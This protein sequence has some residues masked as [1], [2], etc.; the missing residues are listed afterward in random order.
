MSGRKTALFA[1]LLIAHGIAYSQ[2]GGN[3]GELQK[4]EA[5]PAVDVTPVAEEKKEAPTRK[6]V[7]APVPETTTLTVNAAGPRLVVCVSVDQLRWDYFPKFHQYLGEDGFKRIVREGQATFECNYEYGNTVTAAGHATMMTG[8]NPCDHGILGNGFWSRTEKASVHNCADKNTKTVTSAGI[9]DRDGYS[10]F[11]RL[12]PTVGDDLLA[13]TGG[14]AKHLS[15]ALKDRS[16]IM[17]AAAKGGEVYWFD[18][19]ADEFVTSTAY[20]DTLSPWMKEWQSTRPQDQWIGKEWKKKLPDEEYLKHCTI[21]DFAGESS[22]KFPKTFPKTFEKSAGTNYYDQVETSPFGDRLAV[23]GAIAG[24]KALEM[25]K[26]DVPDLLTISLS[27]FDKA[28]H[29]YGADSWEMMDFFLHTDDTLAMLIGALDEQVGAGNYLLIL[30]ADHGIC[31]L[32]EFANERGFPAARINERALSDAAE[33]FLVEKFGDPMT[34]EPYIVRFDNPYFLFDPNR[35]EVRPNVEELADAIDEWI[36]GAVGIEDSF[37]RKELAAATPDNPLAWAASRS[38]SENGG[39]D[40]YL[41]TAPFYFFAYY[42]LG[43]THGTPHEYDTRVPM[44]ALGAGYG[45]YSKENPDVR[46]LPEAKSPRWMATA[47][48]K[49][50]SL[51][52]PKDE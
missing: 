29:Q 2:S 35:G 16:A 42:P 9:S 13:A 27:S 34:G 51:P 40:V 17:M 37:T 44:L 36:Q 5:I 6:I 32:P 4:P 12:K 21:D 43:T 28:G 25:G 19:G 18:G 8:F 49:A 7:E 3:I 23:E 38:M 11:R 22:G 47:A 1:A 14:K 45:K 26:D 46:D 30:T 48:R 41:V 52:I 20:A 33:K 31:P 24:M 50:L 10:S 39:G 15:I